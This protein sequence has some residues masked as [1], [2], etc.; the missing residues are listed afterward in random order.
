MP[1]VYSPDVVALE[2]AQQDRKDHKELLDN[3]QW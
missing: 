2:M 3:Q 1:M